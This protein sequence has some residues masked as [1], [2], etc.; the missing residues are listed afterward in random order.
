MEEI[1]GQEGAFSRE[2]SDYPQAVQFLAERRLAQYDKVGRIDR[3]ARWELQNRPEVVQRFAE[4]TGRD[5]KDDDQLYEAA[6][7]LAGR[8][9]INKDRLE[10]I[11]DCR[12]T[13]RNIAESVY[14]LAL[15]FGFK[16]PAATPAAPPAQAPAKERVERAKEQE[17]HA[18]S[19]SAM[20][21]G[22]SP[23]PE[24]VTSRRQLLEMS[25]AEADAYIRKMDAID[26]FWDRELTD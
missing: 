21:G 20:Q 26:P 7:D 24:T 6:R 4:E 12:E 22:G 10:V 25:P 2:H 23:H 5:P 19:L 1:R 14:D 15:D 11:Q 18:T 3:G 16:P 9:L 8:V 17:V 13:G